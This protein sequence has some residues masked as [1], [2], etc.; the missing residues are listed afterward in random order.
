M[1]CSRGCN[2]VIRNSIVAA[3]KKTLKFTDRLYS[4]IS[5]CTPPFSRNDVIL[6]GSSIWHLQYLLGSF[7]QF[8]SNKVTGWTT[9]VRF[10]VGADVFLVATPS[11]PALRPIQPPN[12]WLLGAFPLGY[13][14]WSLKIATHP[15]PNGSGFHGA[16]LN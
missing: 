15:P 13:S 10:L 2:P 14:G 9:V 4:T 16:K 11:T 1:Q 7:R 3:K 5:F 6:L 8:F 12:Q